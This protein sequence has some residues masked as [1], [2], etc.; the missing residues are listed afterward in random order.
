M[1]LC[2][3]CRVHP[4]EY[5]N[6]STQACAMCAQKLSKKYGWNWS[7]FVGSV[8][9]WPNTIFNRDQGQYFQSFGPHP[10][11]TLVPHTVL[12]YPGQDPSNVVGAD[13]ADATS[14]GSDLNQTDQQGQQIDAAFSNC[15][16]GDPTII[17]QW[18]AFYAGYLK[19][20][21]SAH[22][23]L[24]DTLSKITGT[25]AYIYNLQQIDNTLQSYVQQMNT[26]VDTSKA[27][28]GGAATKNI[29]PSGSG[30]ANTL[31]SITGSIKTLAIIGAVVFA[32]IY[33]LSLY[34][35]YKHT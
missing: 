7:T 22:S 25:A 3:I 12:N 20:S 30:T 23:T 35:E 28:C 15:P 26:W 31:A 14:I 18:K 19:F 4:V 32:G 13:I 10:F 21:Q 5:I 27:T 17:A 8:V 2:K 11:G 9:N 24:N 16:N 33:G 29:P 34:E 6:S 1:I